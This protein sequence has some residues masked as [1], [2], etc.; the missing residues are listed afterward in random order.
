MFWSQ[1]A[2]D[3]TRMQCKFECKNVTFPRFNLKIGRF[4]DK[5]LCQKKSILTYLDKISHRDRISEYLWTK[6]GSNPGGYPIFL[7]F[8]SKDFPD[9]QSFEN[10]QFQ[11]WN[12]SFWNILQSFDWYC[13]YSMGILL[14]NMILKILI[15]FPNF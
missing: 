3:I 13:I 6:L 11:S 15:S 8:N 9:F 14:S 4:G 5:E 7:L 1:L 12:T 10:M 2:C